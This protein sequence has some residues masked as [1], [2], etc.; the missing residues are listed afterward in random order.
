MIT[1]SNIVT[2]LWRENFW[3]SVKKEFRCSL[4]T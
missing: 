2:D 3:I 4:T 1:F